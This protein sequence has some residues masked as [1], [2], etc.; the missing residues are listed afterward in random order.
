MCVCVCTVCV[1]AYVCWVCE[2]VCV[3]VPI[4]L[5]VSA[6]NRVYTC[7]RVCVWVYVSVFGQ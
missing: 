3:S 7:V 6:N 5:F 1:C 4:N 2:S